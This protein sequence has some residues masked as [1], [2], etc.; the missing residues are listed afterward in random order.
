MS[1]SKWIG[2]RFN[3]KKVHEEVLLSH[4]RILLFS[5]HMMY[6]FSDINIRLMRD[7]ERSNVRSMIRRS[8]AFVEQYFF[9]WT[10]NVLVVEGDGQL[11]GAI[12]LKLFAISPHR[13]GGAIAWIVT[14]PEARGLGLG[15]C[16][17]EAGLDFLESQGCNE[18]LASVEGFNTSSSKLF[19]MRGFGILSPIAQF[20]R[21][22]WG[23]FAVWWQ[24]SHYS[25]LGYFLWARP[26]PLKIDSP[27]WQWW[28]TIAMNSALGFLGLWQLSRT[29]AI[30]PIMWLFL[31]PTLILLFGLRYL[32]MW[33]V[34]RRQGLEVRFRTW[35]SAFPLAIA[36]ALVFAGAMFPIPGG[37]YPTTNQWRYR[38]WLPTLGWVA[39]AG[40][41]P[42]L[43]LIEGVWI[44]SQLHLP[45]PSLIAWLNVTL[46]L[47]KPLIL[48]DIAMP[49]F[50]FICFNGRRLWD[51]N[52]IIWGLMTAAVIAVWLFE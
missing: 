9:E 43:L 21:Y 41:L 39:F 26:A 49:F 7:D 45:S 17:V 19:A 15:Q 52:K 35:E 32:G 23:T 1:V 51:W 37:V 2:Y 48:F 29:E 28:G 18:I 22:G 12:V 36:I 6:R 10:P 11:L 38:D 20:R 8:F 13:Q 42:V 4:F 25:E 40:T 33:W 31:P 44:L 24:I 47:G 27:T 14:I 5:T 34:A 3:L 50:P 16:L 46:W 30:E